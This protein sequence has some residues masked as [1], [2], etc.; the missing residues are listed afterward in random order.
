MEKSLSETR[1]LG[2]LREMLDYANRDVQ[3]ECEVKLLA[4]KIVTKDVADRI[5]K[6]IESIAGSVP[7]EEHRLTYS[8]DDGIR[9]HVADPINIHKV[10][11]TKSF[12]KI[13][14]LV[15]RK[16]PYFKGTDKDVKT[17]SRDIIDIPDYLSRFTL[18]HE[19]PIKKDHSGPADDPRALIRMIHRFSWTVPSQEFRIDFSMVKSRGRGEKLINILK[20]PPAYELEIEYLPRRENPRAPAEALASM[21]RIAERILGAYHQTPFILPESR[22]MK[23]AE[24]FKRSD[25]RFYNLV[26]LDRRNLRMERPGNILSGYTVTNKADGERCGLF[27]SRDRLL[28]RVTPQKR[29]IWT[30]ITAKDDTHLDDFIDGEFI[31]E[32]N[33]FCIFDVYR[34]RN[35]N[36]RALPL[37]TTD[38]D[39]DKNPESCRLG[40]ARLFIEDMKTTF[41]TLPSEKPMR[42][43]T[44]MFLAG[45]GQAMEDAITRILD[46]KFEYAIDG[47]IFT[48]RSSPV[49]PMG[50]TE[51]GTWKRVYKWKPPHQNS[52]DFLLRMDESKVVYDPVL[53][54]DAREGMLFISKNQGGDV[55]YPCE[56]MTGEYQPPALPAD[57]ERIS[58][59]RMRIPAVFQPSAP[60]D[61]N[62]YKI[63]IPMN[64]RRMPVDIEDHRVENDTIVECSFDTE[65]RRWAVLR[66]RYDKTYLYR[67]LREPQYG[68]NILTAENVWTSI[69]VPITEDM[70]RKLVTNPPDDTFEDDLYYRDDLDSRDRILKPVYSF[71]NRIKDS[72]YQSNISAGTTLLELAVGRGG[73]MH[74]WI[75]SKASKVVGIDVSQSNISMPRQGA[76]ARYMNEKSKGTGYIPKALFA[77]GDMTKPLDQQ[78]DKYLN[79]LYG[80]E[81]PKTNYLREFAGLTEFD[82]V[83]CQ[84]AMHYACESE[85]TFKIFLEN[86]TK[87]CKGVFFGTCLD[88]A[89]VY[90]LLAG[91]QKHIFRKGTTVFAEIDKKYDDAGSWTDQFGLQ[92]EVMLESLEKP[93]IEYLV[94]FQKITQLLAENGFE[95]MMSEMFSELYTRQAVNKPGINLGQ[96]EQDFSFL[97]RTFVFKRMKKIEKKNEEMIVI[98]EPEVIPEFDDMPALE[99]DV[100]PSEEQTF[101][102]GITETV[103]KVDVP[104][105]PDAP[106]PKPKVR[107]MRKLPVK[108]SGPPPIFFYSKIPEFKEFTNFYEKP[109][110]LDGVDFTSAEQ[111]F[112]YIK[113]KT[114]G[115]DVMAAKIL[116]NKSPKS[117]KA[118]GKKVSPFDP[119]VWDEKKDDVMRNILY[120]KFSSNP[121]L[122]K[123]LLDTEDR[124]LAEGSRD[125]HWSIGVDPESEKAKN[126]ANWT[127]KNTLGKILEEVRTKLRANL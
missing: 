19:K 53:K 78:D 122:T 73:D 61:P 89:S 114:F 33:L 6:E 64:G 82:A 3:A 111:S 66:T 42:I 57:L 49:A 30:G 38:E 55:L 121:D 80:R 37:F 52:I 76:C 56:T 31:P 22:T 109:F 13:P 2:D 125:K 99:K 127:G 92:I 120:A 100:P 51:G 119:K 15:E 88:G 83:S 69:H 26:T 93:Q 24:E 63:T 117:A 10:C 106:P 74:K 108:E 34:F 29:V 123:M 70:L 46:T 77:Q 43:E 40:C 12:A 115:D 11:V 95:L 84:F 48:P 1:S 103:E 32:L 14:C 58:Q 113:A 45:D 4:G 9:V 68:N 105:L 44:K 79:I 86:V 35:K 87:T 17:T 39:I 104:I 54:Q 50:E 41:M 47:L 62:A 75:R 5:K 90:G 8:F 72:L 18:R 23:Y 25:N 116:K 60:R 67:V 126:P 71:H 65:T 59:S 96:T 102:E 27:V 112:Q 21:I 16:L 118:F 91:K 81:T 101:V 94:P 28:L 98:P 20:L 36:T 85:E 7:K 124:P 107:R 97:Y 110:G